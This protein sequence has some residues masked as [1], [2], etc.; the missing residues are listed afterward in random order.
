MLSRTFLVFLAI[1]VAVSESAKKCYSGSKDN[2]QSRPC[3]TGVDG[4]YVCQKFNCEG[5]KSSENFTVRACGDWGSRCE[6]SATICAEQGGVGEC[7]VCEDDL[8]NHHSNVFTSIAFIVIALASTI[9]I[10]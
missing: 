3:D 4:K 5:G 9:A 7:H 2:F 6:A 10:L 1:V 8:C